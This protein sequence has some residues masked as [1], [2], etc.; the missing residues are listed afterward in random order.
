MSRLRNPTQ[1]TPPAGVPSFSAHRSGDAST[2]PVSGRPWRR[3]CGGYVKMK[4]MP[5]LWEFFAEVQVPDAVRMQDLHWLLS[6]WLDIT[7]DGIAPAG[8]ALAH[9]NLPH[10]KAWSLKAVLPHPNDVRVQVGLLE[11]LDE[12]GRSSLT[13][14][15]ITGIRTTL[16]GSRSGRLGRGGT[17]R[18]RSYPGR[19]RTAEMHVVTPAGGGWS[20]RQQCLAPGST[21]CP[22]PCPP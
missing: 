9:R 16:D 15:L 20:P 18:T 7:P 11:D 6:T 22:S 5:V 10:P 19:E 1:L 8:R 21:S 4:K 2:L 14:A 17:F 13:E 12:V 3:P